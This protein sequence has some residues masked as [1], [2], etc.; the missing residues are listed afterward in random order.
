M[1][2]H[3][4]ASSN[5]YRVGGLAV[6]LGVGAAIATSG[7]APVAAATSDGTV[8]APG[9]A[10]RSSPR[11]A[12]R[13]PQRSVDRP[14]LA[15]A[16]TRTP[17]VQVV[18]PAAREVPSV[19]SPAAATRAAEPKA[20][21]TVTTTQPA[22]RNAAA[23]ANTN[24]I[25]RLL[26]NQTPT[27]SPAA[28]AP[29][30][31]V[32]T[33]QLNGYDADSAPLS[34][35][36]VTPPS[37]G[38]VSIDTAGNYVYT[39]YT[40][41]ARIAYTDSFAVSVSD[42]DTGFHIHGLMGLINMLTFGLLGDSGHT[43]RQTVSVSVPGG[44]AAPTATLVVRNP[45]PM[46]GL[47]AGAIIGADADADPLIYTASSAPYGT[48]N[49]NQ[50]GTFVY[51][52]TVQAR[53][54]AFFSLGPAADAFVIDVSDGYGGVTAVP[55][56]VGIAPA[57]IAFTFA[58]YDSGWTPDAIDAMNAASRSLA[59]YF[60]VNAPMTI[61]LDAISDNSDPNN[62]AYA[63]ADFANGPN[64]F[65]YTVPQAKVI[66]GTDGNGASTADAVISF[67]WSQPWYFSCSPSPCSDSV[68]SGQYDFKAVAIHELLHAVGFLTG[69]QTPLGADRSWT[70]Y[71]TFL[72][73]SNGTRVIDPTTRAIKSGYQGNFTGSNNGL[74]FTG[75]NAGTVKL[76][77]PGT[78][79]QGSSVSH[80]NQ[81]P[82][83]VMNPSSSAGNGT[84]I[85][86]PVEV[87][88]LK[89]IGYQVSNT[90]VPAFVVFLVRFRRRRR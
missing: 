67:N 3:M 66:T 86:N 15:Q 22:S 57:G 46:T 53:H 41:T 21:A 59:S 25:A 77:T 9:P 6:A 35:S 49:V 51:T 48:V 32:V 38:S 39:P 17:D 19:V 56:S 7:A 73:S 71:D 54:D 13:A 40:S 11:V 62:L 64:G 33:G 45:D 52:P 42:A 78:W 30:G 58:S 10:D 76:Y 60:L 74:Y 14:R 87:G 34:Y 85:L 44:N 4:G 90:W 2:S 12:S 65:Y 72:S 27:M 81:L 23:T 75:P 28:N 31:R 84:R 37:S 36:I 16:R 80:V 55:V 83:Y 18:Q 47:V 50:D 61:T 79:Q 68:P 26:F 24:P 63:S 89:D 70:V 20:A 1:L 82:N 8:S 29:A 88:I 69:A 5:I 43:R